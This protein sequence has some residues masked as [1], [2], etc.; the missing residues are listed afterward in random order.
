MRCL[1]CGEII[2]KSPGCIDVP[3]YMINDPRTFH[4]IR[5]GDPGDFF[6]GN[7]DA[8]CGDC[9][10]SYGYYHHEGCDCGICP[11]CGGQFISCDCGLIW[12]FYK[13]EP[14]NRRRKRKKVNE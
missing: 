11:R 14:R 12:L 2:G 8:I 9:G 6:E 5:V 10:A 7:E 4:R 13:I 3:M 1:L